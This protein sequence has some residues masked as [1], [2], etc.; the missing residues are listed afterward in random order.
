MSVF[1]EHEIRAQWDVLYHL[2]WFVA[3]PMSKDGRTAPHGCSHELA[4]SILHVQHLEN[5]K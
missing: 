4:S 1:L 3:A 5:G 2:G